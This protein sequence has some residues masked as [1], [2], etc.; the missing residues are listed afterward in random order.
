VSDVSGRFLAVVPARGGSKRIPRKNIRSFRGVPLLART[1]EAVLQADVF[2]S[3]VV[4]TDDEEIAS[5]ALDAG[6]AVPFSR[7]A[8][9][10]D[11]WTATAPVVA[12]AIDVLESDL[13]SFDAVCCVYPGA[14]LMAPSDYAASST[15]VHEALRCESVVAAVVRYGHPIQ[16]ALRWGEGGVLEPVG[17]PDALIQRT[18]DLE[19][20]WHDAGQFYWA[21]PARWRT[22]GPLLSTVVP[23]ELPEWR[24]QDIDTEDDW[25][26]AEMISALSDPGPDR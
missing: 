23:Y 9:L 14:V 5:V 1:L 24:V 12:H 18:Q 8:E 17:G 4:S 13:G 10:S 21:S 3:V 20:M 6:A 19:P 22:E 7:P 2:H 25:V 26:R 16:R 11:D 15:L